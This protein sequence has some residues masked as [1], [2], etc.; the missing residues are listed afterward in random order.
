L[1][2]RLGVHDGYI[3][4]YFK[5]AGGGVPVKKFPA[6]LS[7]Y[8]LREKVVLPPTGNY[9]KAVD[10]DSTT[11]LYNEASL[12]MKNGKDIY[13][14]TELDSGYLRHVQFD[15]QHLYMLF[16]DQFV[17]LEKAYV[18]GKLESFNVKSY[19]QQMGAYYSFTSNSDYSSLQELISAIDSF[20][21]I[22][23]SS[24]HPYIVER[25]KSLNNL[26]VE[27]F[28]DRL[29]LEVE[30]AIQHNSL[31]LKY[32]NAALKGLF[33]R[34]ADDPEKALQYHKKLSELFPD[35]RLTDDNQYYYRSVEC[36]ML[37]KAARDSIERVAPP[38]DKKLYLTIL[39]KQRQLECI[40][41]ERAGYDSPMDDLYREFLTLYPESQFADNAAF[42]ILSRNHRPGGESYGVSPQGIRQ[43]ER[44]IESY[45]GSELKVDAIL[46]N[47]EMYLFYYVDGSERLK[48]LK[49]AQALI[50]S[51][52]DHHLNAGQKDH[53]TSKKKQVE[54]E[55]K[56]YTSN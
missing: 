56:K 48:V 28:N 39:Q 26:N 27:R 31:P 40:S 54:D 35:E 3:N 51:L 16:N 11:W 12:Y 6:Q 23:L 50:S 17:V 30:Q 41:G 34:H 25:A 44:F 18:T 55:I 52:S 8:D 13:R 29:L 43:V 4:Y 38:P 14:F 42:F 10:D 53:L 7:I 45:P 36:V 24:E 21:N 22:Y 9:Y 19:E 49:K 15:S 1:T 2:L 20:Q 5:G 33:F 37:A 47:I 32:R 46:L